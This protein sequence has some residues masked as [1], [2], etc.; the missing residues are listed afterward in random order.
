[1]MKM[2]ALLSLVIA[3]CHT[4]HNSETRYAGGEVLSP[5]AIAVAKQKPDFATH[6]KPILEAKC[7]M[8]HNH[9]SLPGQMSLENAE[10]ALRAGPSGVASIVPGHPEASLLIVN[11]SGKHAH[12]NAMPAVGERMTKNEVSILSQWIKQGATWPRGRAGTLDPHTVSR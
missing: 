8:C 1:M 12:V 11:I 9:K 10:R 5:A 3:G 6:I 7:V 4:P 2:F